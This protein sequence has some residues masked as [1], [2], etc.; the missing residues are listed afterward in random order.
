MRGIDV[1][2]LISWNDVGKGIWSDRVVVLYRR[3]EEE[4][5]NEGL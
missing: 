2:F 1:G 4:G 3:S 5:T